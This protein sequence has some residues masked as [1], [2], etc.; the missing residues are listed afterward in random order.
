MY[1]A[2]TDGGNKA[3]VKPVRLSGEKEFWDLLYKEPCWIDP[4]TN[5]FDLATALENYGLD[6][7]FFQE[8]LKMI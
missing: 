2:S 8:V 5:T 7:M 6:G 3:F 1:N 4:D